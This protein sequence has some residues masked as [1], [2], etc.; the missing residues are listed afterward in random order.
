MNACFRERAENK[1]R[2]MFN[3][4]EQLP[5][6]QAPYDRLEEPS[7]ADRIAAELKPRAEPLTCAT[8]SLLRV[9]CPHSMLLLAQLSNAKREGALT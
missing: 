3:P 9:I 8:Q 5:T 6:H 2:L 4:E 1:V 7:H